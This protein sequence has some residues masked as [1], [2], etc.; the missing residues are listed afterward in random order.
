MRASNQRDPV[1]YLDVVKYRGGMVVIN[2][3]IEVP[4]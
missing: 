4:R 1:G 3:T 2:T